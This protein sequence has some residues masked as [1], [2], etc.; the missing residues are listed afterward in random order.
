ML[1]RSESDSATIHEVFQGEVLYRC[2][3]FQR[4]YVWEAQQLDALWSDIDTVLEESSSSRF[5]G[6]IVLQSF[7]TRSATKPQAFWVIDGQQRLTTFYLLILACAHMA[8]KLGSSDLAS[9]YVRSYLL[10]QQA[11]VAGHT[12]LV[13][14]IPDL[15]QFREILAFIDSYSPVSPGGNYGRSRGHLA[16]AFLRHLEEIEKRILIDRQ[17]SVDRLEEMVNLITNQ[18]EFVQ[19]ILA[20]HHD[21][22]EVFNRLNDSGQPLEIIDLVR[23]EVFSLISDDLIVAES[24]YNSDWIEFEKA[25][26]LGDSREEIRMASDVRNGFFFPFALT[27]NSSTKK[28]EVFRKLSESWGGLISE[29][30]PHEG[31]KAII[32]EL[33]ELVS[34]YLALAVGSRLSDIEDLTWEAILRLHRMPAPTTLYPY[35]MRLLR[36]VEVGEVEEQAARECLHKIES[37]LVRRSFQGQEPTGLHAVFKT[38]WTKAGSD[39]VEVVKAVQT[40]TIQFPEDDEFVEDIKTRDLYSRKLCRYVLEEYER[41]FTQGDVLRTF[42]DITTDHLMPQD[43]EGEWISVVSEDQHK[44]LLHTWANLAPLSRQANSEKSRKTWV[45][46]KAALSNETVFSTTKHIL[47]NHDEWGPEQ[48]EVDPILWTAGQRC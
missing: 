17:P 16:D 20:P 1:N 19:I 11:R 33:R 8:E 27:K 35:T 30:E 15:G 26:D 43:R 2:P 45:E 39:P 28:S 10:Q 13:S 29:L 12:K 31:A 44:A 41:T 9:D 32:A 37:F 24:I 4:H 48:I 3:L 34:S 47:S 6:A 22:N 42:P 5:L 21:A 23:N 7:Q 25:F 14:T 38:L 46:V 36:G 40:S 18:V